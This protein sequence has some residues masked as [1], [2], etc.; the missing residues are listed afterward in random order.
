MKT[1]SVII[2]LMVVHH[3]AV[4]CHGRDYHEPLP[5]H[6]PLHPP[7]MCV[8]AVIPGQQACMFMTC[9]Y[10]CRRLLGYES[11]GHCPWLTCQCFYPC[12]EEPHKHK[13][14]P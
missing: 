6:P 2:L 4:I 12:D 9:D 5:L 10:Q 7:Y 11:Y 14:R 3:F 13:L 8:K 1:L